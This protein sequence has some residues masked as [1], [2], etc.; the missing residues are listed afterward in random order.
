MPERVWPPLLGIKQAGAG[1]LQPPW[2]PWGPPDIPL[3]ARGQG[4]RAPSL[5]AAQAFWLC[6]EEDGAQ[7]GGRAQV[8]ARG[9]VSPGVCAGGT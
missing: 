3:V 4:R 9:H 2:G 6:Q 7:C 5:P 1:D 8:L